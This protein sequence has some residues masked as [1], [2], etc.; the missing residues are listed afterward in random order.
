MVIAIITQARVGSSRLPRKI[1]KKLGDKT[2]LD[3][4]LLG[5]KKSTKTDVVIIATTHEEG[6]HEI[7][8]IAEANG[9]SVYQGSTSDVLSRYYHAASKFKADIIVRVTSDCP[10]IDG[11]LIDK[12][13]VKLIHGQYDIVSTDDT[14]P[15]GL[16]FSVFRMSSLRRAHNEAKLKSAEK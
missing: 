14:F 2:M 16:D 13:I 5:L 15:D 11:G 3:Y 10:L 1:L 9:F 12:A 6:V 4:H 7:I 8:E